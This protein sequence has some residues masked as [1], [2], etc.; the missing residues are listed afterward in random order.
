MQLDPII[1]ALDETVISKNYEL[2]HMLSGKISRVKIGSI[3]FSAEGPKIVEYAVKKGFKVFLDLKYHD[4]PN[5]VSKSVQAICSRVPVEFLTIHAL[6]GAEMIQAVRQTVDGMKGSLKPK[7]LS[8]T[9][10][11]SHDKASLKKIGLLNQ[12]IQE[13]V[14]SLGKLSKKSGSDGIVCSAQEVGVMHEAL[15]KNFIYMVPGIR[16]VG[17][18]VG[19][20]KRVATPDKAMADGATYL[21]IGR[22]ITQS[23]DPLAVLEK[24]Q[25]L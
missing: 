23:S 16:L 13:H 19:D 15:G 14:L 10:L 24:I 2:M 5:T 7:I 18:D 11:T 9:I 4:I 20:Q 3:L 17:D 25:S 12:N 22:S 21:V 8:V 1:V 6:G